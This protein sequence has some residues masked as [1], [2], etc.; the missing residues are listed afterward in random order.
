MARQE[1]SA[2]VIVFR[3]EQEKARQ[4]LLLDYGR[5][6]DFPK[7]HVERGE[8]D[9]QAALRE[10]AEETGLREVRPVD[11]F[12]HELVYFFRDKGAGGLIRKTVI[13]FLAQTD[14]KRLRLSHEHVGY[15]F[16]PYAQALDKLTYPTAKKALAAAEACLA[17]PAH[18]PIAPPDRTIG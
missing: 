6:W 12:S 9:H 14:R 16:L 13:L 18:W 1:R 17:D 10:L 4:Y 15:V 2:G 11:G 7:G 3:L 5:H 8:T